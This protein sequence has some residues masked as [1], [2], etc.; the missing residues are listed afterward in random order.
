MD[1]NDLQ[2][3]GNLDKFDYLDVD[4]EGDPETIGADANGS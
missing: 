4:P 1:P 3:E 2:P